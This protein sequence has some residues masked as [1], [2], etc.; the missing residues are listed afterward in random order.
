MLI[1]LKS[2]FPQKNIYWLKNGVDINLFQKNNST[3][4]WKI[5]NGFSEDDFLILYAGIFGYAQGLEV[6]LHAADRT[7]DHSNIKFILIGDGP[8]KEKLFEL[9][10]KL[11]LKNVFFYDPVEKDQMPYLISSA[12]AS[13]I[14]LKRLE[15]FKGAIPSK[16]F[17][18]LASKKPIILGVEG[19]AKDLFIFEGNCGLAFTPEDS[20]DL[21]KNILTLYHSPGLAENYG[22]N[23]FNYVKERFNLDQIADDFYK[24]LN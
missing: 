9:K 6:I 24:Q 11:F 7:K 18:I 22:V 3:I 13:I 2:R 20:S 15:L 10:N 19:E 14:P 23:G 4:E 16:I 21:A 12:N 1:I 5:K 8:E 17:E